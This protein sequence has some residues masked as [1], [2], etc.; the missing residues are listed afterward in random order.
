VLGKDDRVAFQ[1]A[2]VG[3]RGQLAR[4][5]AVDG[6]GTIRVGDAVAAVSMAASAD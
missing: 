5:V 3:R 2:L 1:Q 4:V 6:D